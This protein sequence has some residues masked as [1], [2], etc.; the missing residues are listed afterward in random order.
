MNFFRQHGR[1]LLPS[2]INALPKA[3]KGLGALK[4][5][6]LPHAHTLCHINHF[7]GRGWVIIVRGSKIFWPC[8][9]EDLS[10]N[11][12]Q[13]ALLAHEL[14]HVWQYNQGMNALIYLIRERGH[15]SYDPSQARFENLGYEQQASLVEDFVRLSYGLPTRHALRSVCL[16]ELA[17]LIPEEFA[18]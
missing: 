11:P 8:L 10:Q 4:V 13:L 16:D 15:Y 14:V 6:L 1:S 9:E 12:C 5:K 2:E 17:R 18:A 7:L 3:V